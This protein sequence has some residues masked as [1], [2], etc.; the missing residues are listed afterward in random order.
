MNFA[1]IFEGRNGS[2]YLASLL[3]AH[4][5]ALCYP[6]VLLS[7]DSETQLAVLDMIHAGRD[8]RPLTPYAG[9]KR[10]QHA[11]FTEKWRNRPFAA[12]GLKTKVIDLCDVPSFSARLYA[13]DFCLIYLH[14]RNI[15]KSVVSVLNA[16]R[17]KA[18]HN[19]WNAEAPGQVAGPLEVDLADFDTSLQEQQGLQAMVGGMFE[20]Y[21]GR[22]AVFC[23]EDM[24]ANE[25]VFMA[26]LFEF[27]GLPD[28]AVKGRF[29]KATDD[30]LQRAIANYPQFRAHYRA[31]QFA[32]FLD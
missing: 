15:L 17:L 28:S 14:R 24:L 2:S 21:Q 13:L 29:F 1:I 19:L 32:K 9:N 30:D 11:G 7:L 20:S 27:L 23:Y 4:P 22:K 25:R 31:S 8:I 10:Y 16:R 18:T 26:G 6:E 3:N 5:H 12:T